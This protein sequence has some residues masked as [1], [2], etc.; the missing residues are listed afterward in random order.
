M[1]RGTLAVVLSVLVLAA[2]LAVVLV[3][4]VVP[5]PEYPSLAEQPDPSIPGTVAFIRGDDPPCLEVV[6]AGGG[7]SRELRCG[8]DIGGKGLAWTSDGLIVTFDFSAYPP[9]YAL[10]DPASAQVVERIDAGQGG[11][12][13]LFAESGTSRRAD[14]TVLIA[15]R[16]ADGATLMIREPNK[17]PRLLLEVNGPRNY[18]F[19]TVT[20]SPDGNWVM[21]ID[22]ESHLLIVHALGDPQPRI[23]A[24]GLQP[25]MSAAWYIPGFDGF[26]VPG[27]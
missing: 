19:N 15:D 12:E 17:E 8:R 18:R 11:P 4:G 16:S 25:W 14:G 13:P 27:R 26:E 2:V 7:V 24:D 20:W 9:Q 21:V 3:F 23:L 1:K 22:S 6:P 10:I 5:F